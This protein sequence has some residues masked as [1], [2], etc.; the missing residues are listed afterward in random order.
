MDELNP[1]VRNYLDAARKVLK[2][3][4]AVLSEA[5]S[6][7]KIGAWVREGSYPFDAKDDSA[8]RGRFDNLAI[9]LAG[10]MGSLAEMSAAE[11]GILF[12]LLKNAMTAV[13]RGG[14]KEFLK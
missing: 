13:P 14:L 10:R 1:E 3:H 7:G 11:R 6:R 12:K 5:E 4:F 9:E 8:Q 2:A